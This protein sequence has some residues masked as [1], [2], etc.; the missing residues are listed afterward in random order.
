MTRELEIEFKN[1]LTQEEY[2]KLLDSFGYKPTDAHTQI[3]HYFDTADYKLRAQKSALRIRQKGEAYEC[4]LK[5]PAENGN[6]EITDTLDQQQAEDILKKS[7]FAAEEVADALKE[8]GVSPKNLDI[9][10]TLATHRIEFPYRNGLLVLD[11][12]EYHGIEDFELEFEVDDFHDGKR[13]FHDLLI[14]HNIPSRKTDKKIARFMKAS[15][16]D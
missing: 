5:V 14:E 7:N 4:T 11:H 8:I 3:N 6:Y 13:K 12:S 16:K 1:L 9:L 2:I 15:K 10:G